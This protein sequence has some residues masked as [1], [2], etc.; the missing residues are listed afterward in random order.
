MPI[1]I[2]AQPDSDFSDPL[3]LL[4]NCHRRIEAFLNS[5][6][7]ITNDI[8]GIS[9]VPEQRKALDV[10]LRY[11]REAAPRHTAD[12]EHSLFPRLRQCRNPRVGP[13]LS[14]L[15]DLNKDHDHAH[16]QHHE[17][18][19]LGL[20]WLTDGTLTASDARGLSALLEDLSILYARHIRLEETSIFPQASVLLEPGEIEGIGR[21]MAA[22][23]GIA[24][25]NSR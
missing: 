8:E 19:V 5:I 12:E 6:V 21:E 4:T 3:G 17:V 25:P 10:S 1:K 20:R 9:L 24:V 14:L 13:I 7:M 2:G 22:R 23:R 11:F 16:S 15:D 18:D